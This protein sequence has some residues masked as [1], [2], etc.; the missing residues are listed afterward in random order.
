MK[1]SPKDMPKIMMLVILIG[2]CLV[3]IAAT[4]MNRPAEPT[5][6][7]PVRNNN[8]VAGNPTQTAAIEPSASPEQ[9]VQQIEEWS[10][11][12][13]ALSANDPFREVLPRD[14]MRSLQAQKNQ[15]GSSPRAEI[16]GHSFGPDAANGGVA[17]FGGD[18]PDARIDFPT[19]TVQGVVVDSSSGDPTSFATIL[20]DNSL[21]FAKAGDPIGS[22]LVVEKVSQRGV[23][24]R[25]AKE[26]C[27]IEVS[28]S[29]RPNGMAAPAPPKASGSRR[30]SRRR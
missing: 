24:I 22:D 18:L 9:Y 7:A 1:V 16:S 8:I 26:H 17:P 29:Y 14:I 4:L 21:R 2:G 6:K 28:K 10:K 5:A 30:G 20:V 15:R 25:A 27:F 3:Y 19:I 13:T 23:Q 12:P 11:P